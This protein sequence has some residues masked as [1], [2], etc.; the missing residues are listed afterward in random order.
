MTEQA[1]LENHAERAQGFNWYLLTM[2]DAEKGIWT[3]DIVTYRNTGDLLFHRGGVDGD[4]IRIYAETGVVE[5]GTYVNAIP[6]IGEAAFK[7]ERTMK[8]FGTDARTSLMYVFKGEHLAAIRAA[9]DD[10]LGQLSREVK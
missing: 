4:W 3:I 2:H 5:F 6:H 9:Q 10:C 7:V 8:E 1:E